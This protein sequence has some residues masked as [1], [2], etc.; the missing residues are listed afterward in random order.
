MLF[1]RIDNRIEEIQ[2]AITELGKKKE[3]Y[4][5]ADTKGKFTREIFDK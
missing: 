4:W 2:R 5:M 3:C 1:K